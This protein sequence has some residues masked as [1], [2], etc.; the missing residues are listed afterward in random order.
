MI[1]EAALLV[2]HE[3]RWNQHEHEHVDEANGHCSE[4]S[5]DLDGH[6]RGDAEGKMAEVAVAK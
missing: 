6:Y 5:E 4:V 2:H 3:G 1:P